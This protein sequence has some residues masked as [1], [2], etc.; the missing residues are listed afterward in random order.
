MLKTD[1]LNAD[2]VIRKLGQPA[3]LEIPIRLCSTLTVQVTPGANGSLRSK[4]L[5]RLCHLSI[6]CF[7]Q[8]EPDLP[9]IS[10]NEAKTVTLLFVKRRQRSVAA[11]ACLLACLLACFG[12]GTSPTALQR[13]ARS[14]HCNTVWPGS[15]C[16][17]HQVD[18]VGM[19]V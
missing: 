1:D 4:R 13:A 3:A 18:V 11:A 17:V 14:G 6:L 16:V 19:R 5:S 8:D 2:G 10:L 9:V 12:L 15:G 7:L